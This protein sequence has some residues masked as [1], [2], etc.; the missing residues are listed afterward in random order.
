[1]FNIFPG[2]GLGGSPS[3]LLGI[4]SW[5]STVVAR[6]LSK[7]FTYNYVVKNIKY[8]Y[9]GFNIIY[10]FDS[11][12]NVYNF[13]S[14]KETNRFKSNIAPYHFISQPDWG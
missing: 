9:I 3:Q 8:N 2:S 11:R 4:G 12:S 5:I 13:V 10:N 7:I 14:K 1:M 6:W